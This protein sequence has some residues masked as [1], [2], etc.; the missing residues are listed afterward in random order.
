MKEL[1][2]T[3]RKAKRLA[4]FIEFNRGIFQS[5]LYAYLV[6]LLI[7]LARPGTVSELI[8]L[9]YL[10]GFLIGSGILA[11]LT[12]RSETQAPDGHVWRRSDLLG[13]GLV[14]TIVAVFLWRVFGDSGPALW[15]VVAGSALVGTVG[16]VTALWS[17]NG[18]PSKT[19]AARR[20]RGR[21]S[22]R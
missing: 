12:V 2:G 21:Q 18:S 5:L 8:N 17:A 15:A 11:T 4:G 6:L 20:N 10:L 7:E 16:L 3:R 22:A 19:A 13:S 14:A 9:G 1:Q